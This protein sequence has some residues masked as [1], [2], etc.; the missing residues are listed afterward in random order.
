MPFRNCSLRSPRYC[1]P[2]ARGDRLPALPRRTP[3]PSFYFAIQQHSTPR[4]HGR[5]S[6]VPE[7]AFDHHIRRPEGRAGCQRDGGGYQRVGRSHELADRRKRGSRTHRGRSR[8]RRRAT[9]PTRPPRCQVSRSSRAASA[10]R[11]RKAPLSHA[12]PQR[13]N[14]A[15]PTASAGWPTESALVS[16]G[17]RPMKIGHRPSSSA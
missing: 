3:R 5:V 17:R 14:W 9:P 1:E 16:R 15:P 8:S 7:D 6:H 10:P 11:P 12:S 4:T 13:A 2:G